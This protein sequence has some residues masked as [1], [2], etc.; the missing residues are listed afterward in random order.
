MATVDELIQ[1]RDMSREE[2]QKLIESAENFVATR[3]TE[4]SEDAILD[5]YSDFSSEE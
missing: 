2:A 3:K 4:P 1:I 5:S